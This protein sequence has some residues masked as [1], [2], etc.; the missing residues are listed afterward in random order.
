MHQRIPAVTSSGVGIALAAL[1]GGSAIAQSSSS[2]QDVQLYVGEMFG[3][4]LTER[5]LSGSVPRLDDNVT[6]GSRYTYN[7]RREFGLQ[8][9]TGYTPARATHVVGGDS[10]LGLTTLDLDAV[11]YV[12]PYFAL[13]GHRFSAYT[14]AG[15]GYAWSSLDHPLSG[16]I[17]D[18]NGYTA[19]AGL[20]AE[21][22]LTDSLFI[23]LDG[24]YRYLSKLTSEFGQ[25]LNTAATTF[26]LGYQF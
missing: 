26:G 23:D 2:S 7:F 1:G 15:V 19:N 22:Y 12:I 8:L 9:S 4:R 21:Y 14:V 25:G 13:A 5:P 18:R 24:R 10:D 11:W 16:S 20:G 17:T 3:D 6:F